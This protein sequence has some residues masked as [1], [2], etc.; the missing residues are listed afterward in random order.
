MKKVIIIL[1]ILISF[2]SCNNDDDNNSLSNRSELIIGLWNH[3]T[4]NGV[5][6]EN[7]PDPLF[8]QYEFK[9]NNECV[10]YI[11]GNIFSEDIWNFNSDYTNITFN[12]LTYDILTL[13]SNTLKLSYITETNLGSVLIEEVYSRSE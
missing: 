8:I 13:E 2:S 10:F 1:S 12:G 6:V 7:S 3:E 9:T 4:T 5:P 11:D